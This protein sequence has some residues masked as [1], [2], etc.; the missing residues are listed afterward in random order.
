VSPLLFVIC[1]FSNLF[2]QIFE[3]IYTIFFV[4]LRLPAQ[5]PA[6]AWV[7][8]L[9]QYMQQAQANNNLLQQQ[10]IQVLAGMMLQNPRERRKPNRG[11]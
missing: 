6:P 10:A 5:N 7:G 3:V 9:A 1:F 8:G 4:E 2:L 11:M